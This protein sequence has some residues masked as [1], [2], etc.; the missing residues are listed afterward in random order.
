MKK[1][2]FYSLGLSRRTFSSNYIPILVILI[3]SVIT[4]TPKFYFGSGAY[5]MISWMLFSLFVINIYNSINLKLRNLFI[6]GVIFVLICAVYKI[7]GVSSASI[8]YCTARPFL[9]FAPVMALMIIDRCDNDQQIRFLFHFLALAIAINIADNIRLSN[10]FGLENVAFQNLYGLLREEGYEGLNLGGSMFVNMTVFYTCIMFF[11]FLNSK[12][13]EGK[14]LFLLYFVISI[15]FVLFFSI[16]ASVVLLVLLS[17]ILMY[18]SYR[19]EENVKTILFLTTIAGGIIF[20]FRDSIISFLIDII[21]SDRITQRLISLTT[22]A[23]V[24]DSTLT[25]RANLWNVSLQSWLSSVSSFFFGIGDHNWNDFVST[26]DSGI[27]SHSDLLDVLGRYGIMGACILYS[28]I[29]VFYNYL[30]KKYGSAFKWEIFSFFVLM[31][32]MGLSKKFIA[33]EPPI[34]IFILFPLALRCFS[35]QQTIKV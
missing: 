24:Q 29:K 31:I 25:G 6:L 12:K 5:V 27:G 21:G 13:G 32:L 1:N 20:L 23:D 8:E 4:I 7:I 34:V 26:A 11:A 22:E 14:Y 3:L 33:P 30:Q 35:K 18:I 2:L 15:S 10:E 16:K 19:S 17:L 9:Y 28:S